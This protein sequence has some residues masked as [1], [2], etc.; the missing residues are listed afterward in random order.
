MHC[1]TLKH[2]YTLLD[3]LNSFRA[4]PYSSRATEMPCSLSWQV[5]DHDTAEHCEFGLHIVED[6]VVGEIKTVGNLLARPVCAFR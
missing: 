4:H 2:T 3:R 5:L 1:S 6:A